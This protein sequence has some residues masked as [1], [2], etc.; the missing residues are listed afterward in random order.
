MGNLNCDDCDWQLVAGPDIREQ[1][2]LLKKSG[3]ILIFKESG[4]NS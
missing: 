4:S 3:V 1:T 2:R